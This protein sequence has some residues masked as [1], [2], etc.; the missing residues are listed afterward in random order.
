MNVHVFD[1]LL[2]V[3]ATQKANVADF[4][5]NSLA[6]LEPTFAW[7]RASECSHIELNWVLR[8]SLQ[9]AT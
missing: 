9:I 7:M 5:Q 2:V 3:H 6:L 4:R 1:W 8:V